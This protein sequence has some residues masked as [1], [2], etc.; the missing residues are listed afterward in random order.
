MRMALYGRYRQATL[1]IF[2]Y[3]LKKKIIII[4][5]NNESLKIS[6]TTQRKIYTLKTNQRTNIFSS[7]YRKT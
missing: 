6:N 4:T 2:T 7:N 5:R 1:I 3:F